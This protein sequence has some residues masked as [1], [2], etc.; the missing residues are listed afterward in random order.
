MRGNQHFDSLSSK[1]GT[2]R[3]EW[4]KLYD[5][6]LCHREMPRV[7]GTCDTHDTVGDVV[8]RL[9]TYDV[10]NAMVADGVFGRE[11]WCWPLAWLMDTLDVMAFA[12]DTSRHPLINFH[13]QYYGHFNEFGITADTAILKVT[14]HSHALS[15]SFFLF[16][17]LTHTAAA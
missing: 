17:S 16:L 3:E 12:E 15:L 14:S 1:R 8:E 4:S 11:W 6:A 10:I 5:D 2:F 9:V 13:L 7:M